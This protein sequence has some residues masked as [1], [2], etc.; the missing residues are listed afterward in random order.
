MRTFWM[1]TT[2]K[3]KWYGMEWKPLPVDQKLF[4]TKILRTCD[5]IWIL[6][7]NLFASVNLICIT[8]KMKVFRQ[9]VSSQ[10]TERQLVEHRNGKLT[11]QLLFH[12]FTELYL[13]VKI[14]SWPMDHALSLC[15]CNYLRFKA[16]ANTWPST[17]FL[18]KIILICSLRRASRSLITVA[19]GLEGH[20]DNVVKL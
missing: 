7:K 13:L 1:T 16:L 12:Q 15:S 2:M 3:R 18:C 9:L 5:V 17:T 11:C 8:C 19:C 6:Q 20:R 10:L 14:I 4:E